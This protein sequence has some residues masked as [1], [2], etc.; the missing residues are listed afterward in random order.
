M[1]FISYQLQHGLIAD[2]SNDEFPTELWGFYASD[3]EDELEL[4]EDA[5]HFGYVYSGELTI[6][7]GG[8][9]PDYDVYDRMYFSVPGEARIY[10]TDDCQAII[11]TRLG[12]NG[13]FSIGGPVEST[14]RLRYI[15]GAM[16][17]VLIHPPRCGDP[18]LNALYFKPG[19]SQTQHIHPSMRVGIVAD[20]LGECITPD[21]TYP[22]EPGQVFV[23]PANGLHSFRT[24]DEPLVVVAYHPNSDTGPSHENH[25]MLN[26]TMVDGISAS[27]LEKVRTR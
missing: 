26:M 10:A 11:I 19:I 25:P 9:R 12:Y 20:G 14:G 18:C 6:D 13:M 21:E 17:S 24:L 8:T 2:M 5:T 7:S 16:D 15:D 3:Y 27:K 4:A 23:I 22:L 1:S